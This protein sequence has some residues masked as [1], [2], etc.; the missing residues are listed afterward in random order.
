MMDHLLV[1]PVVVPALLAAVLFTEGG[2]G[3]RFARGASL[4]GTAVLL[5]VALL[6]F[7]RAAGGG[8]EV[9]SLG[10][11][12]A[13]FG[14]VLVLDRLSALLLVLTAV[15]ALAALAY[16][17]HGWDTRG[18]HF[19]ALF[20]LQLM[21]INGAFL[22]GDLFNL[23]VFFE[24]L[25]IASY[26]LL[27]HG[28]GKPRLRAGVHY[29]VINL[30]GSTFFLIAIGLLYS[31]TG[32]LNMAH[33]A[34]RIAAASPED[35]A[36]VK[37]SGLILFGVFGIKAAAFPL[38]FW[39]PAA[40]ASA[41]APV[42]ALF[43]LMTKVGVYAIVRVST[44]V[45][46]DGPFADPL[47]PW[48]PA[49]AMATLMLGS[50]GALGAESLARLVAYLTVA[51]VGTM[52]IAVGLG[53]PGGL[54][55]AIFYLTHS[56]LVIAALFLLVEILAR[57]RGPLGDEIRPGPMLRTPTLIGLLFF[58]GAATA[59]GLP[60]SSGFF[61]KLMVLRSAQ[62]LPLTAWTWSTVLLGGFAAL[63]GCSRAGSMLVWSTASRAPIPDAHAPRSGEWLPIAALLLCGG[64]MVVFAAPLKS[65][66]DAAALQL[67][68]PRDYADA[69]IGPTP[70]P[71]PRPLFEGK[72]P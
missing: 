6:L 21:G 69:I 47:Q 19:H 50:V 36:L 1:L 27:V 68:T 42:A 25:L 46:G 11:W 40:Y 70:D 30:G 17:V 56:T 24:V 67:Y 16:A 10:N 29:V 12:P 13:P 31:V 54:A 20:Q 3:T 38:Y 2:N 51:S 52:L 53:T 62:D 5:V 22:T 44:L 58:I 65:Y 59:A 41:C 45:F 48:L 8:I 63:I 64:L 32:T 33:L 28:L 55:A 7:E 15:V 49:V 71:A 4:S 14:I 9:Y 35:I 43:S 66:S 57:Q 26:C 39:L 37:A 23:F 18:R 61:G 34:G 72:S 60:P